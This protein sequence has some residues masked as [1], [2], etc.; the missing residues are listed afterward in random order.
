MSISPT[1]RDIV[2]AARRGLFIIDLESSL[3]VP[4][5]LPQGDTWDVADVLQPSS[6]SNRRASYMTRVEEP[7]CSPSTTWFVPFISQLPGNV[8]FRALGSDAQHPSSIQHILHA[9]YRA[10]TDIN[11]HPAA[12]ERDLVVSTGVDSWVWG[13]TCARCLGSARLVV[14]GGKQVKWNRQDPHVLASI[15]AAEVPIWD[16]RIRA[17]SFL[18]VTFST[19]PSHALPLHPVTLC[20]APPSLRFFPSLRFRRSARRAPVY[21][22]FHLT[23]FHVLV[24]LLPPFRPRSSFRQLTRECNSTLLTPIPPPPPLHS[25]VTLRD[26]LPPPASRL[27]PLHPLLPPLN[28]IL[29]MSSSS[30]PPLPFSHP[31]HLPS[32]RSSSSPSFSVGHRLRLGCCPH[33]GRSGVP[34]FRRIL[35]A[36]SFALPSSALLPIPIPLAF[37]AASYSYSY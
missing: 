30:R 12:A 25:V 3:S 8:H 35:I 7:G 15:H 17:R 33:R 6:S 19:S 2:P 14:P 18:S 13:R 23:G 32:P 9:H 10:I 24:L 5:F 27:S 16:R 34:S 26:P 28:I 31:S 21:V 4:R 11:W 20:V 37:P 29:F 1:S 22:A 36:S